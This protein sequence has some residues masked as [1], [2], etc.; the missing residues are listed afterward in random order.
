MLTAA[1]GALLR[2]HLEGI[3]GSVGSD[4]IRQERAHGQPAATFLLDRFQPK[5][6]EPE[7]LF[8][9]V[10]SDLPFREP[11]ADHIPCRTVGRNRESAPARQRARRGD[12]TAEHLQR[13]GDLP[14]VL[15]ERTQA[16]VQIAGQ[17]V[18]HQHEHRRLAA[19]IAAILIRRV[20]STISD[21]RVE[22]WLEV[23]GF[24]LVAVRA[25]A[26]EH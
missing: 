6:R 18:V 21:D 25:K 1:G 24:E 2:D 5:E 22:P 4:D 3:F 23:D 19:G 9:I 20:V 11:R 15:G 16:F 26:D 13:Q 17:H 8:P 12:C 14:P 10:D 7:Q